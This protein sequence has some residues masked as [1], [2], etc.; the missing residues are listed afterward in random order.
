MDDHDDQTWEEGYI[1][2]YRS[3]LGPGAMFTAPFLPL[4]SL[5]KTPYDAGYERGK[6]DAT[7]RQDST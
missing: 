7:K 2:G 3:V 4:P 6:E 1:D 5:G